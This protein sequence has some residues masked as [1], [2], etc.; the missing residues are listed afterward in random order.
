[1]ELAMISIFGSAV[2]IGSLLALGIRLKSH[3]AAV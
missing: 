3:V 1:L 2:Y